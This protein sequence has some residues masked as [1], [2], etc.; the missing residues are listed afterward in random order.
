MSA[1]R[2]RLEE[3]FRSAV[4]AADP[5]RALRGVVTRDG[6]G[7]LRIV[8][9]PL[10]AGARLCVLAVGKAS[11]GMAAAL[12]GIAGDEIA[13][14]LIVAREAS[15]GTRMPLRVAA[16]PIPD[17]RSAAAAEEA[18]RF[19]ESARPQ[20]VLVVL[21][22]GGASSL[23]S[24]PAGALHV[25]DLTRTNE[26]L[27]ASG[28]PIDEVNGVRKHLSRLSGG[29]LAKRARSRRI[30]VLVISDVPG[31]RLDVI[32]SGPCAADPSRYADALA[33]LERR[34]LRE[35]VPAAVVAHL[36][37]GARGEV[38]ETAKPGDPALTRV[39]HTILASNRTALREAAESARRIGMRPLMLTEHLAGEA[40]RAGRR[41][42]ALARCAR[43]AAP[44]CLLAGG[45]TTVT[46]R[47]AGRGGRSQELALAAALE[48]VGSRGVEL[49]AAG[50]D[51]SDG[52][53]DAAGA[54]ADAGTVARAASRG[55][56]AAASLERND[57]YDFFEAAGGLLRTGPTGTNVM[58]LVLVALEPDA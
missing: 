30:E 13:A 45:E 23:L 17:V 20:D 43:V 16:H 57:A 12:E 34:A 37:A 49:L 35:R 55:C 2:A 9:Q 27:L 42:G 8:G 15:G 46:L 40:R 33:V 32:G 29:L 21:L 58:D 47:G 14:G 50:T 4:A 6:D 19:V 5:A 39:R 3:I 53:T 44:A 24:A 26:A 18:L 7:V 56:D 41:I 48:L 38:P 28:A 52:P 31:D 51:G 1:S 54:F 11:P 22:S 25:D 10:A 36:E